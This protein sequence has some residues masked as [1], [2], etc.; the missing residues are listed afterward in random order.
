MTYISVKLEDGRE[1]VMPKAAHDAIGRALTP[2]F[3]PPVDK[4]RN[5]IIRGL[6]EAG[7]GFCSLDTD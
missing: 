2:F 3:G 7:F 1:V 6:V 4:P 5:A